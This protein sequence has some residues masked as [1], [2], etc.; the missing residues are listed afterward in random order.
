M[1]AIELHTNISVL[2]LAVGFARSSAA[3]LQAHDMWGAA[4][5][6]VHWAE[7]PW[8]RSALQFLSE[9]VDC[10]AVHLSVTDRLAR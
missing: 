3:L 4:S 9:L 6:C 2:Q 10:C 5:G 1:H 8:R 7:V